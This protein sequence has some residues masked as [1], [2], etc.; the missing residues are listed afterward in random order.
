MVSPPGEWTVFALSGKPALSAQP[1]PPQVRS[2]NCFSQSDTAAECVLSSLSSRCSF[3]LVLAVFLAWVGRDL[4]G[5]VLMLQGSFS[6][7]FSL[8]AQ[9]VWTPV[10]SVGLC[11]PLLFTTPPPPCILARGE[12]TGWWRRMEVASL[13]SLPSRV[14]APMSYQCWLPSKCFNICMSMFL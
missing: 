8:K 6:A 3:L 10:C 5:F 13:V 4:R 12:P 11:L 14:R 7:G 1:P 9:L 2:T